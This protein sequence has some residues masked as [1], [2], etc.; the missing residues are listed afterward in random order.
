MGKSISELSD[1]ELINL[2][3]KYGSNARLWMRKFADLLPE[4][5]RRR[6]YKR[7]RCCS[8]YEFA[9][10]YAGMNRNTVYQVLSLCARLESKPVLRSL[11]VE[12]GWT[13][14]RVVAS[15]AT[16]ETDEFFA[17]KVRTLT[18]GALELFVRDWREKNE[19][20]A[21]RELLTTTTDSKIVSQQNLLNVKF[22]PGEK[23]EPVKRTG[24]ATFGA[25]NERCDI[26]FASGGTGVGDER[27]NLTFKL[28]SETKFRLEKF[29][30]KLEKQRKEPLTYNQLLKA[31]LDQIE[32]DS[33]QGSVRSERRTET[34]QQANSRH[35]PAQ[36]N[37][38][39]EERYHGRCAFPGCNKP[40]T[41]RHH[42]KRYALHRDHDSATIVPLCKCHHD[43][44]HAGLIENESDP[45]QLWRL[46]APH[47]KAPWWDENNIVDGKV[48]EYKAVTIGAGAG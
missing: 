11:L 34:A 36:I 12:C 24:S 2:C 22:F 9:A 8:I 18:K 33:E 19:D 7:R 21:A 30:Q 15:V 10:K 16:P 5:E 3:K 47:K 39:L 25:L 1:H 6:L 37:R 13:K 26:Q 41:H 20:R 32:G 44:A 29:K 38:E 42:T 46:R 17:G 45:P 40:A 31:M 43:L 23:T 4:V 14:L 35:I 28:D 48:R 27:E